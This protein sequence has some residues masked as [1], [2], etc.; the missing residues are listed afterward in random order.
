MK[1]KLGKAVLLLAVS[2]FNRARSF[3]E[4][5][6]DLEIE[7]ND[8]VSHIIYK[9][10]ISLQRDYKGIVEGTPT[11]TTAPTGAKID[12]GV[13]SN[14]HQMYFDVD[15]IEHWYAK[16]KAAGVEFVHG[17][18]EYI[19]GQRVFR[20]YDPDGHIIEFGEDLKVVA[21]RFLSQGKSL[22]EVADMFGESLKF[23]QELV[24]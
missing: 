9:N 21:K 15:D 7:M 24:G 3:Y 18:H 6:L 10:G 5:V 2:D 22:Q 11:F 8:E 23:I 13:R 20:I 14:N 19:W 12:V 16:I 1:H 17:V 4:T